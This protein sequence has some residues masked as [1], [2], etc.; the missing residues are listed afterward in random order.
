MLDIRFVT[1]N[2]DYVRNALSKRSG[3][4]PIEEI[5]ALNDERKTL[6]KD[7]EAKKAKK[8]AASDQIA[9]LKRQK[10]DASAIIDEMKLVG[11]EIKELD[12]RLSA[13]QNR[14]EELLFAI[15]NITAECVPN[16][17]DDK[18]N[19]EIR[20]FSAPKDFDFEPKPHWDIGE[21]LNILDWPRA[22]KISGARFTVYKG[23]G[24][25]LE[26]AI[27]NFML[28]THSE[29][30]YTEIFPPYMVNRDSM[31]GTGQLPKFEEDM[32]RI[33]NTNYFLIPTA[34]VPVT[35]LHRN[36][37]LSAND[38]P[39]K[40]CAYTA[41][42]RAE[43]GSAGRDTR[44]LIRQHQFNKVELVKFSHPENSFGELESLTNDAE[45]IL[46]LLE[47]PYRVVLLCAGDT[48]FSSCMTY[49]IEV[50]M[51]SYNRYVEIS[52]CSNFGDFQARRAN[53]KFREA[54]GKTAFAHTLNGSGLAV[55]RTTAAI[56][57]NF[58]NA[59]GSVSI[60]KVL[61]KYTGFDI[62]K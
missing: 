2:I 12:A 32:F 39:I 26:R 49:D 10:A 54:N 52:S 33:D 22:A 8:N 45:K 46:Q 56:L 55:G 31:F 36:E 40:Y 4:Y 35:N 16:G 41:C 1:E 57:E 50:W 9:V 17:K 6:I 42:F 47:I 59:D 23:A 28:D 24:A 51:P 14:L 15:P 44:G 61:Q 34:E 53:I 7:V 43:A 5:A 62:I 21:N 11:D 30:G 18:D 3:K 27:Y 60:P 58:Q 37:I 48:G 25:R 29:N 13:V 38:L 19:K 20:R